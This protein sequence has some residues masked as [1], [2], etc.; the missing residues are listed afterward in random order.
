LYREYNI[1]IRDC[2][3]DFLESSVT[4]SIGHKR[5]VL[6]Q[7]EIRNAQQGEFVTKDFNAEK[8]SLRLLE[9]FK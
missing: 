1:A 3:I 6:L 8:I 9:L 7:D 5:V 4:Q 2:P